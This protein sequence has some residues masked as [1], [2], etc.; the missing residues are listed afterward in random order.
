MALARRPAFMDN[1]NRT[2][3]RAGSRVV[4]RE[5]SMARSW[6]G[7]TILACLPC[8]EML[9]S[10]EAHNLYVNCQNPEECYEFT[11]VSR[12]NAGQTRLPPGL[13]HKAQ[14]AYECIVWHGGACMHMPCHPFH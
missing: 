1:S 7:L 13:P 2:R 5:P 6:G 10:R 3:S 12:K 11:V 4:T 14:F 9:R 8:M